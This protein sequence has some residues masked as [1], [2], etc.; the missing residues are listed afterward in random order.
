M[1]FYRI[2]LVCVCVCERCVCRMYVLTLGLFSR[3]R[4]RL[5]VVLSGSVLWY[6]YIE[7]CIHKRITLYA[8]RS[9]LQT[10]MGKNGEILGNGS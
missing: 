8:T 7:A 3:N 5:I 4:Y 2:Q 1:F 9:L 10:E 6:T